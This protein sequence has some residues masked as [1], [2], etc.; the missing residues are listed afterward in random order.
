MSTAANGLNP[1][2]RLLEIDILLLGTEV[3]DDMR[4]KVEE[5]EEDLGV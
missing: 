3:V 4:L 5:G 1:D 2:I